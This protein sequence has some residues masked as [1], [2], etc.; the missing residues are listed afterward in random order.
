MPRVLLPGTPGHKSHCRFQ[1][2]RIDSHH[3]ARRPLPPLRPLVRRGSMLHRL[4]P[5]LLLRRCLP[6]RTGRTNLRRSLRH[7]PRR[8]RPP[9]RQ[10]Q[11]F[12]PPPSAPPAIST[13]L[14]RSNAFLRR[15]TLEV[16]CSMFASPLPMVFPLTSR[17]ARKSPPTE[18]MP[19]NR[20]F[21]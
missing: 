13:S 11:P 17:A 15:S 7:R 10:R 21:P 14:R 19:V 16:Q 5:G 12:H 6:R 9:P 8:N 18:S 20:N 1:V 3:E 4:L 2:S